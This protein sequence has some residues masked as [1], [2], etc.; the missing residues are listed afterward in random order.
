M[1]EH[2]KE[3]IDLQVIRGDAESPQTCLELL[4]ANRSITVSIDCVEETM[5][6]VDK[7]TKYSP[8]PARERLLHLLHEAKMPVVILRR[9]LWIVGER[10]WCAQ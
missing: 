7:L 10:F 9:R 5:Q 6:V 8:L 3:F 1:V 4:L 2:S